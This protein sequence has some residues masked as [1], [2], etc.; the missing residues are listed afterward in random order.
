MQIDDT[1]LNILEF[2]EKSLHGFEFAGKMPMNCTNKDVSSPSI[3]MRQIF[4]LLRF[5]SYQM[6]NHPPPL[7]N[8]LSNYTKR[9]SNWQQ[10]EVDFE[11]TTKDG[12][13]FLIFPNARNASSPL[14][15]AELRNGV[16]WIV[17]EKQSLEIKME[18]TSSLRLGIGKI[19]ISHQHA[20]TIIATGNE[21]LE[22]FVAIDGSELRPAFE[23]EIVGIL[24]TAVEEEENVF[25]YGK[26]I[27]L[28]GSNWTVEVELGRGFDRFWSGLGR[29]KDFSGC[30]KRL[31]TCI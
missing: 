20:A 16:P 17:T 12:F 2:A 7:F 6:H 26:N 31:V 3:S 28:G 29:R 11:S 13:L 24:E 21:I 18:N 19:S 14:L 25:L 27:L 23:A 15:G 22:Y 10:L 5:P 9:I 4:L 1:A 8:R 30:I